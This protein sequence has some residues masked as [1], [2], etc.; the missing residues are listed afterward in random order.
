MQKYQNYRIVVI[1]DAS[2]DGTGD[3]IS[4][5]LRNQMTVSQNRYLLIK[6]TQR[7]RA[8]YNLRR[9]AMEFCR[10]Q[11]I[12]MIVDGDD[13]LIGRYVLKLFNA[14]FNK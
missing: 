1:D 9:A 6:N 12:F 13:E 8:M 11:Q 2:T 3:L 10:P 7:K 5:Y 14:Y 4:N